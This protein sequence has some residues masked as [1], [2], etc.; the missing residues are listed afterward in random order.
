MVTIMST[1]CILRQLEE[2][3]G[4]LIKGLLKYN[5]NSITLNAPLQ[6]IILILQMEKSMP[7]KK[8][9]TQKKKAQQ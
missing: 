7:L 5:F 9:Q 2:Y 6:T 3:S 4:F 8:I 1:L